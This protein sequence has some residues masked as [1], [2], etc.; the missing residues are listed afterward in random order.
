[1]LLS[2]AQRLIFA[3]DA[4]I[5]DLADDLKDTTKWAD[6]LSQLQSS[7]DARYV[8]FGAAPRSR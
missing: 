8:S 7:S 1:M 5:F 2:N 3:V 6:V 4:Y